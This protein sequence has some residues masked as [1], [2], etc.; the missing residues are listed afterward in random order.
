[1]IAADPAEGVNKDFSV[2]P[3][4]DIETLEVVAKLRGQ[5]KPSDFAKKLNELGKMY[6]SPGGVFPIVVVERNNHGHAVLLALD[7]IHG[8]P[9]L[10]VHR[11]EKLGW[12]TDSITRPLMIDAFIDALE[13]GYLKVNDKEILTECLTLVDNAGKIEAASGKFDDCITSTAIGLQVC[14]ANKASSYENLERRILV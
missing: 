2:T 9:N 12:K 8:Y 13:D 1:V 7:E 10:Y 11:D 5:W 4:L 14:F 3:V 6:S